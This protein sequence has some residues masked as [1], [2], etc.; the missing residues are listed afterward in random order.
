MGVL[1]STEPLFGGFKG[2]T[3][4]TTCLFFLVVLFWGSP[5]NRH[6]RETSFSFWGGEGM[7]VVSFRWPFESCGVTVG[8]PGRNAH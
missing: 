5:K 4:R 3:R 6:T 2:E 7:L 8:F 1:F